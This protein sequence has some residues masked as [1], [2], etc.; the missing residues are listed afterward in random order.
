MYHAKAHSIAS[1]FLGF[2]VSHNR[3]A[4]TFTVLPR[5]RPHLLARLRPLGVPPCN[6][7]SIYTPPVFGSRAPQSPITGPDLSPSVTLTQAKELQ[8]AVGFLLYYGRCVDGRILPATCA[9]AS[10]QASPTL[11]TMARLQR[12][13]DYVAAHP[14]G[15][16]IFRASDMLLPV[17]SDA[18]FLS[19]PNVLTSSC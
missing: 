1:K 2:A 13:L 5:L 10:E 8:V 3:T 14:D 9:L 11:S 4:C 18:S 12:L 19:L 16:K 6:S 17:L 15:R 7:P